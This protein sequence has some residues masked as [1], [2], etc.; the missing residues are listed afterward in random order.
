MVQTNKMRKLAEE[1]NNRKDSDNYG[2]SNMVGDK[3]KN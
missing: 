1:G 2:N 3:Q